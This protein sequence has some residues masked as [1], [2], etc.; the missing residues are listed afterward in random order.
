MS[1]STIRI[2]HKYSSGQEQTH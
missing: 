2:I 1:M